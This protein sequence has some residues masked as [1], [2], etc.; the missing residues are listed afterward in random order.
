MQYSASR[1]VCNTVMSQ[2]RQ[3]QGEGF[4]PSRQRKYWLG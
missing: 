3:D 2:G 4:G 1:Q